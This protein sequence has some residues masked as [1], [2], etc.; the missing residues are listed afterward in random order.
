[1]LLIAF[2]VF[3]ALMLV[4]N[5]PDRGRW[6]W[7]GFFVCVFLVTDLLHLW[8]KYETMAAFYDLL[9]WKI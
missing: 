2:I 9:S 4:L 3:F 5:N 1:M 7:F 8:P 6:H